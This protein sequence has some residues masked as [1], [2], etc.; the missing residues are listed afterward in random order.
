M[1]GKK[2]VEGCTCKRHTVVNSGQFGKS[3]PPWNKGVPMTEAGKQH[4]SKINTGK[5]QSEETKAKRRATFK[6]P[7]V[8]QKSIDGALKQW[9]RL[10]PE[11]REEFVNLLTSSSKAAFSPEVSA[12]IKSGMAQPEA[13]AKMTRRTKRQWAN[14]SPEEKAVF[15]HNLQKDRNQWNDEA[16]SKRKESLSK[17]WESASEEERKAHGKKIQRGRK[18][19][20]VDT[21][22]YKPN[23]LELRVEAYLNEHF[24]GEWQFNTGEVLVAGFVPDFVRADGSNNLLEVFG[25]YWHRDDNPNRKKAIYK[26]AGFACAVIWEHEFNQN[27][28]YLGELIASL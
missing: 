4:L 27:P 9:A 3:Q 7:E 23:K 2:C 25:S 11:E 21:G 5:K 22:S 6:K 1:N 12:R 13:K 8:L 19:W 20:H 15:V 28:E 16:Q 18:K 14:M 10:S 26:K 17:Y 24:P